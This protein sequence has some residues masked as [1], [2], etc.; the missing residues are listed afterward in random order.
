MKIREL[1]D[2]LEKLAKEHGD[3]IDVHVTEASGDCRE[4]KPEFYRYEWESDFSS[5]GIS[6]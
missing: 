4:A 6:L 1:I 3:D 2:A 5:E